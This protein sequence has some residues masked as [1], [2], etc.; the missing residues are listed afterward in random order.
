LITEPRPHGFALAPLHRRFYARII[1]IIAVLLL[2][3]V[4]NGFLVR[5]YIIDVAPYWKAIYHASQTGAT[6]NLPTMS[7]RATT[8]SW[9][10]PLLAMAI[11]AAY[12]VPYTAR[13]GQTLGKRLL[14]IRVLPLE[15]VH[16][17]GGRRAFR[18]WLPLGLPTLAWACGIGFVFQFID[19]ISPVFNRPLHL[20]L[21]DKSAATVVVSVQKPEPPP[22]A[23]GG[24][25]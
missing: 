23:P 15:G 9:V 11:W 21:H 5:Q 22:T 24:A 25:P 6:A 12:E 19:S 4:L 18:R 17:L 2:N 14:G 20:A 1:D 3:V 10:I 8:L 13:S 16:E 7:S